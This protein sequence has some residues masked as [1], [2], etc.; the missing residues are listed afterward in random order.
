MAAIMSSGSALIDIFYILI[1]VSFVYIFD[2]SD[3]LHYFLISVQFISILHISFLL[4]DLDSF[5]F[6]KWGLDWF[7]L[8]T[9]S[10]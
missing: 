7:V 6:L 10:G 1:S 3:F 4:L 9:K 2:L 5:T 8:Q